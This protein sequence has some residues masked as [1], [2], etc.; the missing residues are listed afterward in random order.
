MIVMMNA[1]GIRKM[2]V[3]TSKFGNLFIHLFNE[4]VHVT[5]V[6]YRQCIARFVC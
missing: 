3:C 2:T 5:A 4:F 6:K 1:M